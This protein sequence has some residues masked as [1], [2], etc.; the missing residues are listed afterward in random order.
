MNLSSENN[1][2]HFSVSL[3]LVEFF[4]AVFFLCFFNLHFVLWFV[5]ESEMN[6]KCLVLWSLLFTYLPYS[7]CVTDCFMWL[8]L[9]FFFYEIVFRFGSMFFFL[10]LVLCCGSSS[11]NAYEVILRIEIEKKI[12]FELEY[13]L[14]DH[15]FKCDSI[16]NDNCWVVFGLFRIVFILS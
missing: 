11:T 1:S 12:V 14:F 9:Y 13:C 5:F 3:S 15:L 7:N 4:I 16:C 10:L 2:N 6:E 8:L